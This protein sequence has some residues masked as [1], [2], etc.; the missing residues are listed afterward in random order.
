[1]PINEAVRTAEKY[2]GRTSSWD[3]CQQKKNQSR[4]PLFTEISSAAKPGKSCPSQATRPLSQLSLLQ[5]E[6][7]QVKSL[8]LPQ[9]FLFALGEFLN[10]TVEKESNQWP[11]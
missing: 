8:C 11:R 9:P 7:E 1:M 2:P 10:P 6:N 5:P 3:S 4:P